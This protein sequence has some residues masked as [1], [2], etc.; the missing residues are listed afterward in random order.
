MA[1]E[2]TPVD[3]DQQVKSLRGV[4][5]AS[6][7]GLGQI[8]FQDSPVTGLFFLV[9]IAVV[10]PLMAAGAAGGALLGTLTANGLRYDAGDIRDGLYGY[11]ASLVGIA[12]LAF[13]EPGLRTF[14]VSAASCVFATV[15]THAM[16]QRLPVPAYTAPFIVTTWLAL[17]VAAR[18]NLPPIVHAAAPSE[19]ETLP[20]TVAVVRGISEVMFQAN[21]LT[22]VLFVVGILL[23]SWKGAVWAVVGSLLGLL[24]GLENNDPQQ[25]LSLGIYGYNAALAAMALALYRRSILMPIVGAVLS[26][27]IT[28]KF[29]M[30]GLAT[31][32]APFVLACWTVIGL[33]RLDAALDRTRLSTE[34]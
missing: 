30:L 6:L 19:S 7:N 10:S 16:R 2:S 22:G 23:R 31:L 25:N 24:S 1:D 5:R 18:L 32:T 13:H 34:G 26:V 29:P 14:V 21:V 4:L 17:F 3:G 9:G 33:D 20:V 8:M 12:L 15:L 27:P 11:N 28:E